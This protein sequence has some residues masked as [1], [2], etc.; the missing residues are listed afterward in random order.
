MVSVVLLVIIV[1]FVAQKFPNEKQSEYEK[2]SVIS[3]LCDGISRPLSKVTDP[4][5]MLIVLNQETKNRQV[6]YSET[7]SYTFSLEGDFHWLLMPFYDLEIAGF[8]QVIST[9]T[10]FDIIIV[11]CE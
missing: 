9:T 3:I 8:K 6:Y 1:L 11:D 7:G 4:N 5:S 10:N 2:H